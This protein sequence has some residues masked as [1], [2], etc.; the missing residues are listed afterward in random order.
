MGLS[1]GNELPNRGSVGSNQVKP[2]TLELRAS[3]DRSQATDSPLKA[4]APVTAAT[5]SPVNQP[6]DGQSNAVKCSAGK[7]MDAGAAILAVGLIRV[8][9]VIK[10]A[11][12][13]CQ[14]LKVIEARSIPAANLADRRA[15]Q[16]AYVFSVATLIRLSKEAGLLRAQLPGFAGVDRLI[17]AVEELQREYPRMK[18]SR[19]SGLSAAVAVGIQKLRDAAGALRETLQRKTAPAASLAVRVS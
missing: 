12:S 13:L 16:E 8:N 15:V 10:F 18:S 5:E 9:L 3:C 11:D 14:T 4:V 6:A 2:I 19:C 17:A 7:S 1:S